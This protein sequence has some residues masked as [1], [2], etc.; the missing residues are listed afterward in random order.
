MKQ[1]GCRIS[2]DFSSEFTEERLEEMLPYVDYAFFSCSHL[3][4]EEMRAL[5]KRACEKGCKMVL[6][7]RGS[8]GAYLFDG[9]KEYRQEPHLVKAKDTMAAGDS[10]LT[11]LMVDYLTQVLEENKEEEDAIRKALEHAAVFSS[12]QCLIDGSFGYGKHY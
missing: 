3:S 11:C 5:Q 4:L 12:Q 6:A 10:F 2:Y 8:E 9:K 7:T 1:K